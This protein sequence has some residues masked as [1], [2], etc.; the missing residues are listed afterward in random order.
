MRKAKNKVAL[1]IKCFCAT[2]FF[3]LQS[4]A[5]LYNKCYSSSIL[6]GAMVR[7]LCCSAKRK[8]TWLHIQEGY[9]KHQGLL[10]RSRNPSLSGGDRRAREDTGAARWLEAERV[11]GWGGA[12]RHLA[13]ATQVSVMELPQKLLVLHGQALVHL[14]LLLQRLLQH[15]LLCGQLSVAHQHNRLVRNDLEHRIQPLSF[16]IL[17]IFW[18]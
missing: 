4:V 9:L 13:W 3:L 6:E 17:L 2:F 18:C 5:S 12:R 8:Q 7:L 11:R 10:L 14:G 1:L 15:G 16:S